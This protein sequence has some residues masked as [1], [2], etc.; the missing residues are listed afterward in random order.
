MLLRLMPERFRGGNG[1]SA[2]LRER[3]VALAAVALVRGG[4][5]ETHLL[6]HCEIASKGGA[7]EREPLAE[8]RR[9][10]SLRSA[11]NVAEQRLLHGVDTERSQ[12]IVIDAIEQPVDPSGLGAETRDQG[13]LLDFGGRV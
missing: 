5:D 9:I 10:H 11:S 7:V 3:N 12:G 6:E 1:R 8:D 4:R 13:R 2:R